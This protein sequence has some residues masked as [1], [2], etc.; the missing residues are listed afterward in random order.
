[1]LHIVDLGT[2]IPKLLDRA[3]SNLGF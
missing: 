1:M 3:I 2:V